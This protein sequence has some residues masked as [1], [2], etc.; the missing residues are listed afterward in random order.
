MLVRVPKLPP[1]APPPE[2]RLPH[3]FRPLRASEA[4]KPLNTNVWRWPQEL[5]REEARVTDALTQLANR[6]NQ[7]TQDIARENSLLDDAKSAVARLADEAKS[8]AVQIAEA[9][10]QQATA[11]GCFGAAPDCWPE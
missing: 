10:P 8:L 5:S 3:R 6:Q 4:K 2:P 9:S 7:L 1:A 11:R